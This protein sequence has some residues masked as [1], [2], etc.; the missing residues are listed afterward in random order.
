MAFA[1]ATRASLQSLPGVGPKTAAD[2]EAIGIRS[3]EQLARNDPDAL[4]GRLRRRNGGTLDR[5]VLYVLRCAVHCSKHPDAGVK[6]RKW[7]N[8]KDNPRTK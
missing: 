3:P 1:A 2:L 5:C 4:F 7:W 8:W 6:H